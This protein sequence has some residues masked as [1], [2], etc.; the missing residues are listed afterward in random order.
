[1]DIQKATLWHNLQTVQHSLKIILRLLSIELVAPNYDKN[2]MA[3]YNLHITEADHILPE[4]GT[5]VLFS[6]PEMP[7]IDSL[8]PRIHLVVVRL[9]MLRPDMHQVFAETEGRN[10][11]VLITGPSRTV[12]IEFS[13]FQRARTRRVVCLDVGF[14]FPPHNRAKKD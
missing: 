6:F 2:E 13:H 9:D 5:L 7:Y 1:M 4:S 14:I 3:L 10:D 8:L 12:D 11:L